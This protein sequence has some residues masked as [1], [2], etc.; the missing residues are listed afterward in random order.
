MVPMEKAFMDP[1]HGI[2]RL[3]ERWLLELVDAPEFQRLRR[4]RQLGTSF[5]TYHGAEHTRFGH[6]LGALYVMER[7]LARFAEVA[8]PVPE[9]AAVV[10]RAA[11]LLHDVG[12]GPLSHALEDV[13]TPGVRHEE[14]T[15]RI[16]L[17]D[18]QLNRK[19]KAIEPSLPERIAAAITGRSDPPWVSA[20]VS[21]QLDVDR[22]DYLLRD[23]LFT[24][25]DYGRFQ[26]D[27]I[28]H[29][30]ALEGD[31]VVIRHKGLQAAEEYVLARYF[32]YWRVYLHKTTRGQ[33]AL[34]RAIVRRAQRRPGMQ[35]PLAR[36]WSGSP[37]LGDFLAV[38]DA[39]L[40]VALKGWAEDPDPVLAD[41]SRRFLDRRL[42]KPVF[43][44]PVP[45]VPP[46]ALASAAEVVAGMGYDPESYCLL[47]SAADVPY[48][49]YIASGRGGPILVSMPQ[50]PPVE[51]S[52]LSSLIR[53]LAGQRLAAA[54]L[55]VPAE[56]RTLVRRA[57]GSLVSE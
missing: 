12:H 11:A 45:A 46:E 40:I 17:D 48:D 2:I 27:R 22:M 52:H 49:P 4:I 50:G 18:T 42:L 34:L 16:L 31:R 10:A 37:S 38:D 41:L 25:A 36:L 35:S 23:A 56:C 29:T 30:L 57:V 24:G 53:A 6:S 21:S 39:D 54:N 55:Y 44:T 19:L 32:M 1:V 26:L 47:D 28:V 33:E 13:L 7:I 20:L 5:G 43:P 14:W 15:R 8:G 3:R 9:E 51:I